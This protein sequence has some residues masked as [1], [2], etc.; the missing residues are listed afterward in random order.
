VCFSEI[1]IAS[2]ESNPYL[3]KLSYHGT[4]VNLMHID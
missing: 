4:V 3:D 2:M 1:G